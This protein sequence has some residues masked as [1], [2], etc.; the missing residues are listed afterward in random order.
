M[1]TGEGSRT[2]FTNSGAG[3]K[4]NLLCDLGKKWGNGCIC[5][6]FLKV[7]GEK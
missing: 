5:G 3:G 6:I 4:N 2:S 1:L 7:G